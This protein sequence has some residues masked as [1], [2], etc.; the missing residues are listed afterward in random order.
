MINEGTTQVTLSNNQTTG[1]TIVNGATSYREENLWISSVAPWQLTS[2]WTYDV[3][4]LI[5]TVSITNIS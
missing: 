4:V 2:P 5:N 1:V 3:P